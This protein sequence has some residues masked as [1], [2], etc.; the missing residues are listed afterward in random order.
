[1]ACTREFRPVCG[2]DGQTYGNAC[3]AAAAG[4][5]V[6]SQGACDAQAECNSNADCNEAD[7]CFSGDGCDA[8]GIC[9]PR[10]QVCTLELNPV[11]GCN[12]RTYGNPCEAARAGVNVA[13]QGICPQVRVP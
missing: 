9:Q 2:C 11:C 4:V 12:G 13:S 3:V 5:N 6:A 10:P 8:P 7:Y 1:V